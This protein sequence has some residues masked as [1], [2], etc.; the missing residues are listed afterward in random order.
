VRTKIRLA[1]LGALAASSTLLVGAPALSGAS[2]VAAAPR[3]AHGT[4][5]VAR[6]LVAPF[7]ESGTYP[8]PPTTAQCL[9]TPPHKAC[10]APGQLQRAY[11]LTPL[12]NA[13]LTGRGSTIVIVDAF[14][15][16]T[17]KH[18]LGVFDHAFGLPAPPKLDVLQPAGAVPPYDASNPDRPNW[19]EE[20]TLDVEWAHA[21]A[22][23]ANIALVETPVTE[24][25]G[26]Q[27][28][29][30]IVKAENYVLNHN[31]GDVIS[32]SF[33]ATE[34]TFPNKQSLLNL[35]SAF[36]N[37]AS[38]HVPVLG[39]S[40]DAGPTDYKLNLEDLYTHRVNSWPSSD[41]LVTSVGGTQLHLNARGDRTSPDN[42]WNDTVQYGGAVAGGSGL[43][44]V[45]SRPGYQNLVR[46]TV[47]AQRG[48]PDVSLSASPYGGALVY[49]SF[50]G[51]AAG[52]HTFGG[53]SEAS[54]LFSGIVAIATQAAGHRVGSLNPK[55]YALQSGSPGLPD[56]VQ[57]DNTV[58]FTQHGKTYT[59]Q[60][61]R[62][63]PGYDLAT[64][65]GTVNAAR[66]VT[67]LAH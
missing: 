14:G 15:S 67:A 32:Q 40:G 43:S 61:F 17:I 1:G 6:P 48:T 41:P 65:L 52:W 8:N 5:A 12:Y 10:Y 20:T 63:T 29:P 38:K 9:N 23:G 36:T 37:A 59:V 53:T 34:E 11:N 35:R 39:S 51:F 66:L 2:T 45:F 18:D 62:A 49:T 27:G 50:G 31:I 21:M 57:G 3:V 24:T 13:G 55:L 28:F 19:A 64:G 58:T 7:R 60:G 54:P 46:S 16:P 30:E 47:G 4:T 26:V 22:P 44:S 33:G 56:V 25:E 42:V